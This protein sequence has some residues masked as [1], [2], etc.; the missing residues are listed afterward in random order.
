MSLS[1]SLILRANACTSVSVHACVHNVGVHTNTSK[2]THK[3]SVPTLCMNCICAC[4]GMCRYMLFRASTV[5]IDIQT[6]HV[7]IIHTESNP[8][9]KAS[10]CFS[11][12]PTRPPKIPAPP[13][14]LPPSSASSKSGQRYG[15]PPSPAPAPSGPTLPAPQPMT[16]SSE[17]SKEE[18]SKFSPSVKFNSFPGC[19]D[20]ADISRLPNPCPKNV[21]LCTDSFAIAAPPS[22]S[23]PPNSLRQ[24]PF[25]PSVQATVLESEFRQEKAPILSLAN[26]ESRIITEAW[27][28]TAT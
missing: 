14:A 28:A 4:A 16:S 18:S 13:E 26:P 25:D 15:M 12:L 27:V 8:S 21:Q 23:P 17:E 19:E 11:K 3:S 1:L 6:T 7:L 10:A 2:N 9:N 24:T 5:R 20:G 22:P